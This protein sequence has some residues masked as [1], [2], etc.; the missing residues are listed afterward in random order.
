MLGEAGKHEWVLSKTQFKGFLQLLGGLLR[1][2]FASAHGVSARVHH[3]AAG[4]MKRTVTQN[5][6][7]APMPI[8][9]PRVVTATNCW[10]WFRVSG[11]QDT[12]LGE[13][14]TVLVSVFRSPTEHH[15]TPAPNA[16]ATI[17]TRTS[18]PERLKY[19]GTAST[20][21]V[22]VRT[23]KMRTRMAIA[24]MPAVHVVVQ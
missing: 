1:P 13:V 24:L 19:L 14:S 2:L 8:Q 16:T 22:T 23:P 12:I 7:I 9:A 10:V 3:P 21:T 5:T 11:I 20:K 4:P 18:F 6:T 15:T 17:T